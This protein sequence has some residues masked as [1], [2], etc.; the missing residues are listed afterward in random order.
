MQLCG[1]HS[2]HTKQ[3]AAVLVFLL[4]FVFFTLLLQLGHENVGVVFSLKCI[5]LCFF[6][7]YPLWYP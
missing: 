4:I 5:K 2:D 7:R 3:Q 6:A 1:Y